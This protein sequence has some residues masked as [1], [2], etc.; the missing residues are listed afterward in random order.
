MWALEKKSP[1][2]G[3]ATFFQ[4]DIDKLAEHTNT[5]VNAE[6]MQL[7]ET[8]AHFSPVISQDLAVIFSKN[9]LETFNHCYTTK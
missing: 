4:I 6:L 5:K 3:T 7:K 1:E 8:A 9:L 2:T